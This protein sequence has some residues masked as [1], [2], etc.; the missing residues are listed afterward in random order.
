M[1]FGVIF[2]TAYMTISDRYYQIDKWIEWILFKAV[3]IFD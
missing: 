2:L 1:P 3:H